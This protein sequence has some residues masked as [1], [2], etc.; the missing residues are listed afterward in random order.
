[1]LD[2]TYNVSITVEVTMRTTIQLAMFILATWAARV[3]IL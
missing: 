1:M 2:L 3:D